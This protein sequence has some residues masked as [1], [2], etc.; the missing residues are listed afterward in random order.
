MGMIDKNGLKIDSELHDFIVNEAIPEPGSMRTPSS[1]L[2]PRSS[3]ICAQNR[4]LLEKRD[5]FQAKLDDW[6]RKNGAPSDMAAYEAYLRE[7]GYILPRVLNFRSPPKMSIRNCRSRRPPAGR[8]GSNARYAL[9]AANARWGS[10]YDALY[11]RMRSRRQMA[12]RRARAIIRSAGGKVIAWAR[13]FLD[14]SVPL[15]GESWSV[16]QGFKIKDGALLIE[17]PNGTTGPA[18]LT[19]LPAIAARRCPDRA[20]SHPQQSLPDR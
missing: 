19:S 8:S 10:L 16:A 11:G 1:S 17:T 14:R 18:T 9:N 15:A 2:S 12:Q 6:Y 20:G 4:A 7:I 13:D 3:R 5:A